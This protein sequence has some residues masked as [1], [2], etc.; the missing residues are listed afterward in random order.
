MKKRPQV[1]IYN[2]IYTSKDQLK[3]QLSELRAY[4]RKQDYNVVCEFCDKMFL[5][6]IKRD[7]FGIKE[8]SEFIDDNP[9]ITRILVHGF[10]SLSR[11]PM[12]LV[13]IVSDFSSR[14]I[15]ID[16]ISEDVSSLNSDGSVNKSIL[17][18]CQALTQFNNIYN[19]DYRRRMEK[20][21]DEYIMSGG[22]LGMTKGSI[23]K[24]YGD[25]KVQY[26]DE[27]SLLR[28]GASLRQCQKITGCSINT[29]RKLKSMF[30]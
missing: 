7:K 4:A 10:T 17:I 21:R 8:M 26:S 24:R 18:L 29:L 12:D 5:N 13:N 30:M 11:R 22:K 25:Y 14:G 6:S 16:F 2:R 15:Y 23:L 28:G 3:S 9:D 19:E 20:G 27:L 1:V